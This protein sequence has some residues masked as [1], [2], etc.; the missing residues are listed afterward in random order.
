MTIALLPEEEST[1]RPLHPLVYAGLTVL[2]VA[3]V[4]G[5][6][7]VMPLLPLMGASTV[8]LICAQWGLYL[9]RP[10]N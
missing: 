7:K 9:R 5:A 4:A 3:L 2:I 6:C 10:G 1:R 8:G